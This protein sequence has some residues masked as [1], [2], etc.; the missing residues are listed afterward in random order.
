MYGV[1]IR[2]RSTLQIGSLTVVSG[3]GAEEYYDPGVVSASDVL[4]KYAFWLTITGKLT[5]KTNVYDKLRL[6][7]SRLSFVFFMNAET[8]RCYC[9]T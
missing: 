8:I 9:Q 1:S 4:L 6:A 3:V 7:G 2:P 5:S